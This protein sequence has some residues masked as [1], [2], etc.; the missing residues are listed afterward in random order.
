MKLANMPEAKTELSR[1][2]RILETQQEDVIYLARNGMPV[3]QMTLLPKK[4]ERKRI[5]VAEGK[6]KVPEEFDAWECE[7]EIK[8][9]AHPDAMP[10]SAE[11][12]FKYCGQSGY[13]KLLIKEDHVFA[14][15]RLERKRDVQPHKNPFDRMLICQAAMENMVFVTHDALIPDYNQPCIL[16]V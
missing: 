8:R 12:L 13:R 6:F 1:L 3:A 4:P 10:V 11:E 14:M 2:V 7:V 15:K 9:L 16:A 5:G